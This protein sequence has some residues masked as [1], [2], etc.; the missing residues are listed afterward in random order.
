MDADVATATYLVFGHDERWQAS[1][2]Y[3]G[4]LPPI[5]FD[6]AELPNWVSAAH[7]LPPGAAAAALRRGAWAGAAAG[8]LTLVDTPGVG[9]LD[10]MHG[11]LARQAAAGATALLFV[12]DASGPFTAG[13]LAFLRDV[14]EQVET[15]VFALAKTDAFRGWRQ[16]VDATTGRCWP[17]TRRG[18]R[19]RRSTRARRACSNWPHGAPNEQAAAAAARAVR[20]RGAAGRGAGT[21]WSGGR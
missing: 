7:E 11:E 2:H 13:E 15:V 6:M 4:R 18:S 14:G 3:P 12:V 16:V 19:A 8:R 5:E 21:A 10:S 20:H 1:A 17:S 9:G